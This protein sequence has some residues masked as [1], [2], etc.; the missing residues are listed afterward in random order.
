MYNLKA[1]PRDNSLKAKQLRRKGI[2]PA[3]I[4]GH[5]IKNSVLIQIPLADAKLN[6]SIS[7][8]LMRMKRLTV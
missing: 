1:E 5:D 8:I 4:Y 6:I 2:I 7:S 3:S